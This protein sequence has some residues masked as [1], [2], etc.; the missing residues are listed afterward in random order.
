VQIAPTGQRQGLLL[1]AAQRYLS[2]VLLSV[3]VIGAAFA[4]PDTEIP[5]FSIAA[6]PEWLERPRLSRNA[7]E[8]IL[9]HRNIYDH[10]TST[11]ALDFAIHADDASRLAHA[12]NVKLTFDPMYQTLLLHDLTISRSGHETDALATAR[13]EAVRT[14]DTADQ[15]IYTGRVTVTIMLQDVRIGDVVR[16]RA[17]T[18]GQNPI[19]G[20]RLHAHQPLQNHLPTHRREIVMRVPQHATVNWRAHGFDVA[21]PSAQRSG[22]LVIYRWRAD[23]LSA[24][25]IEDLVPADV[26]TGSWLEVTDYNDWKEVS[27]WARCL[28]LNAV[29]GALEF[30]HWASAAGLRSKTSSTSS[31]RTFAISRSRSARTRTGLARLPACSPSVSA[32]ARTS[33]YCSFTCCASSGSTPT[34]CSSRRPAVVHCPMCCPRRS[35]SITSSYVCSATVKSYGSTRR[36]FIRPAR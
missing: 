20:D 9:L 4:T 25:A 34:P 10:T 21:E 3:A 2:L 31:S 26:P 5:G 23:Q 8:P 29:A 28:R 1:R 15:L 11:N 12:S 22:A 27:A 17:S 19:F 18:I 35:Y 33:P 14:E 6:A 30:A 16:Y 13:I 32:T 7:A 24:Q 36:A